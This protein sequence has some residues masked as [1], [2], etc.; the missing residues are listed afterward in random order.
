M[1][2]REKKTVDLTVM[3]VLVAVIFMLTYMPFKLGAIEMTFRMIPVVLG[4]ILLGP[5]QGAILGGFFGLTSFFECFGL[6]GMPLSAFGSFMVGLNPALTAVM[7]FAPRIIMGFC[8]ALIYRSF[9][10][11]NV[12]AHAVANISGALLNTVLFTGLLLVLFWRNPDFIE[13]MQ[14]WGLD[15]SNIGIFVVAFVGLNG[16]IEALV[17]VFIGTA[18]SKGV[19]KAVKMGDSGK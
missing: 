1:K 10:D 19:C 2:A 17:C 18:V 6:L 7:C 8:S 11:K 16:L 13:K 4:G 5:V 9:G 14:S 12:A 3:G 15:T